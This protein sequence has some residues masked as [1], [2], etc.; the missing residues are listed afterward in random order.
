MK[1]IRTPPEFPKGPEPIRAEGTPS[2][3]KVVSQFKDAAARDRAKGPPQRTPKPYNEPAAVDIAPEPKINT[4]GTGLEALHNALHEIG[5][6][7]LADHDQPATL[8]QIGFAFRH[9][10]ASIKPQEEEKT[11][12]GTGGLFN[13]PAPE[14][15][16]S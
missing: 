9:A 10:A 7:L 5:T 16:A 13:T 14:R 3:P 6:S 8:G 12:A 1:L 2:T 15:E 4:D 11:D